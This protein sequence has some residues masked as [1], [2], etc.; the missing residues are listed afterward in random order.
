MAQENEMPCDLIIKAMSYGFFFRAK[1][2][3][4]STAPSDLLFLERLKDDFVHTLV[5]LLHLHPINDL[6]LIETLKTHY[7]KYEVQRKNSCSH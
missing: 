1:D 7:Y 4:G 3:Q 2:E 6:Q 5:D